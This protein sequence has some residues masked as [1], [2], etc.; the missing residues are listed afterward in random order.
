M[1]RLFYLAFASILAGMNFSGPAGT[2]TTTPESQQNI[3]ELFNMLSS[4]T[5]P[6]T[7]PLPGVVPNDPI[8]NMFSNQTSPTQGGILITMG[9]IK[10]TG[11][12]LLYTKKCFLSQVDMH[13]SVVVS[14]PLP[15]LLITSLERRHNHWLL[16][17]LQQR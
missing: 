1:V 3:T 9:F 10:F 2:L 16:D 11:N 12:L 15:L 14:T 7:T 5:T 4:T 17:V 6:S 13:C 8:A